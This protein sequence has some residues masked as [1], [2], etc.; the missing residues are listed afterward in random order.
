MR[1]PKIVLENSDL[2]KTIIKNNYKFVSWL[3][4]ERNGFLLQTIFMIPFISRP[5]NV[6]LSSK[7]F[8]LQ[9]MFTEDKKIYSNTTH[10]Y[11]RM[12]PEFSLNLTMIQKIVK[13]FGSVTKIP[14]LFIARIL[15]QH[16]THTIKIQFLT[17]FF[18]SKEDRKK[19]TR[20]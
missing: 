12:V 20:L 5:S 16:R 13:L 10:T 18:A 19:P 4:V 11:D 2:I 1:F 7:S 8:R 14:V 3:P 17:N 15:M 9:N 6:I